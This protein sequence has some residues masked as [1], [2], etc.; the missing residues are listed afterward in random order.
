MHV[1]HRS[2]PLQSVRDKANSSTQEVWAWSEFSFGDAFVSA[3]EK[4]QQDRFSELSRSVYRRPCFRVTLVQYLIY[5]NRMCLRFL[6]TSE[7]RTQRAFHSSRLIILGFIFFILTFPSGNLENGIG[8]RPTGLKQPSAA[9]LCLPFLSLSR[10]Q[11]KTFRRSTINL[12]KQQISSEIRMTRLC[13]VMHH[14]M[15]WSRVFF[16]KGL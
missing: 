16:F 5:N 8:R 2:T 13:S 9:C 6:S 3:L 10:G 1:R 7:E 14:C 12:T 15:L 4:V 11:K